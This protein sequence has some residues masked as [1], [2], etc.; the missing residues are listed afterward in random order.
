MSPAAYDLNHAV[1]DYLYGNMT[2][3]D[4]F[5]AGPS[6]Y[7]YANMAQYKDIESYAKITADYMA[8]CDLNY[9]NVLD[10]YD[11]DYR[12]FEALMQQKQVKGAV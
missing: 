7:A 12:K 10:Y 1:L 4:Q 9:V 3:N 8:K 11:C 5:I 2:P 6:G